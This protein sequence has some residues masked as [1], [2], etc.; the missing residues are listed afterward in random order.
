[1]K[2][3]SYFLHAKSSFAVVVLFVQSANQGPGFGRVLQVSEFAQFSA[4]KWFSCQQQDRLNS[5]Q[6][7]RSIQIVVGNG[8]L[9]RIGAERPPDGMT[10][11]R[12]SRCQG[13][14][15]VSHRG[16]LNP[17]SNTNLRQSQSFFP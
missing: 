16:T 5:P 1:L 15:L 13:D 9:I 6:L 7:L 2:A 14:R 11:P 8:G 12:L 3:A 10:T 17:R 4:G